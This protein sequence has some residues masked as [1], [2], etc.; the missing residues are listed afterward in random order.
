MGWWLGTFFFLLAEVAG[1][2][3]VHLTS[4]QKNNL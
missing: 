1:F 3:F 2:A 4:K